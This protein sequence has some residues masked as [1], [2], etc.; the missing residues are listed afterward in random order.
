MPKDNHIILVT[1]DT[2]IPQALWRDEDNA[3]VVGQ[4]LALAADGRIDLAITTRI[5]Y[6]TPSPPLSDRVGDLAGLGVTT[7][8]AP[9]TWNVS[10]WNS[11]DYWVSEQDIAL[12]EQI[13]RT[14]T[15]M[16]M[17]LPEDTDFAHIF[18]HRAA[19]RDIFLTWDKPILRAASLLHD[20]LDVR[21]LQ[22]EDFIANLGE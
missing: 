10:S 4:L 14:L 13:K 7:I 15:E 12:E 17:K 2:N 3:E 20:E 9:F 11:G 1:L 21:I 6:D 16:R 5:E 18:G 19:E 8:G 22:P